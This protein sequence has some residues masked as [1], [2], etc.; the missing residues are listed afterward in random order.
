M[1]DLR[2]SLRLLRAFMFAVDNGS[3]TG[4]ATALNVAPS[5]VAAA[6]G[7][8]EA[9]FGTSLV[10]RARARGIT[11]TPAG[12]ALAAR[13]R[14]LIE[15]YSNVMQEGYALS[16]GLRG[17]LN[18]GYYAPVA[19]AFLP[20]ILQKLQKQS[21]D[22]KFNL[23]ECD[24]KT[25]QS[26]LLDGTLD[27]A[28]FAGDDLLTGV[29]TRPL[30]D[31]PPYALLPEG[32]DL[33]TADVL[34]FSDLNNVPLVLLDLPVAGAY[35]RGLFRTTGV[36]PDIVATVSSVEMVR[37][38]VGAGMGAAVLN[39]RPRTTLSY[40]GDALRAIPLID[41]A[42]LNLVSGR[43]AGAPR[44]LVQVFQDTLHS[45]FNS[46]AALDLIAQPPRPGQAGSDQP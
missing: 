2:L 36:T 15:D 33:A 1:D 46:P 26:G 19:P 11:A 30:M 22:L 7:R 10:V 4:A 39:M 6:L 42:S 16:Q 43:A 35:V 18:I 17:T 40:G 32:H 25:A 3:I 8:V 5:A 9:E 23:Q 12:R 45:W 28:L 41:G 37:S 31:L 27:I 14:P 34:Q 21:L 13:I 20:I 44:R 24:N 38:L 29:E